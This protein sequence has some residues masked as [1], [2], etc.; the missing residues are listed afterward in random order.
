MPGGLLCIFEGVGV[1][2][3]RH[4]Q[5]YLWLDQQCLDGDKWW[6][7]MDALRGITVGEGWGLDRE[8]LVGIGCSQFD[9][10]RGQ[11]DG[12]DSMG[13]LCGLGVMWD[14]A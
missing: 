9:G 2:V 10:W 14:W 13:F 6:H 12:E 5:G 4:G 8:D 1:A 3:W 11:L 7:Y